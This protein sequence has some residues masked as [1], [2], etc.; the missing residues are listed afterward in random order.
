MTS[1]KF[2]ETDHHFNCISHIGVISSLR[3]VPR[4]LLAVAVLFYLTDIKKL[5]TNVKKLIC[6]ISDLTLRDK[7]RLLALLF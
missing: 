1:R 4:L 7:V 3:L 2:S 6:G 5:I